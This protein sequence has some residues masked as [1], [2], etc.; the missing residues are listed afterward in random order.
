MSVQD[1][2]K[3]LQK[4]VKEE[5][6]INANRVAPKKKPITPWGY[7]THEGGK[8]IHFKFPES[9]SAIKRMKES[10]SNINNWGKYPGRHPEG[11]Y[12]RQYTILKLV[13]GIDFIKVHSVFFPDGKVWDSTLREIRKIRD[14]ELP[15]EN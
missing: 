10:V 6:V 5:K 2:L 11:R 13:P 8:I 14:I 3:E 1:K 7:T 12:S 15:K 4:K 9:Q